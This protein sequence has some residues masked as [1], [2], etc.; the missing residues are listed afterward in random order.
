MPTPDK[1]E[2]IKQVKRNVQ[3]TILSL[4]ITAHPTQP[5]SEQYWNKYKRSMP[6]LPM[7][8]RISA[9]LLFECTALDNLRIS[10]LP[11][12]PNLTNTMYGTPEQLGFTHKFHVMAQR[13]RA[14][15]Q[16]LLDLINTGWALCTLPL[17]SVS[18]KI[19]ER[20]KTVQLSVIHARSLTAVSDLK[21]H[22]LVC[23]FMNDDHAALQACN[24]YIRAFMNRSING[25]VL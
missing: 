12:I 4:E 20:V 10:F 14:L 24:A 16:W 2:C 6:P 7:L 8:W 5:S 19:K 17:C 18:K 11:E 25:W 23:W 9:H 22:G 3:A 1:G 15:A 21:C 13:R